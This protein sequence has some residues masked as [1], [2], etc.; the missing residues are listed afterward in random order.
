MIN[1]A[2]SLS[3]HTL[4]IGSY[5]QPMG[6]VPDAKGRGIYTATLDSSTGA[7]V[8]R[9]DAT[10]VDNPS[11]MA[12][13][14]LSELLFAVSESA[15]GPSQL[16]S[17][18]LGEQGLCLVDRLTIA[19]VACCHV[20]SQGGRI[21]CS[22]Y[23]SGSLIVCSH[24]HGLLS[25]EARFS[26]QGEGP[27]RARQQSSHIHQAIV[28]PENNWLYLCDL[29]ADKIWC[30]R[31]K[32]TLEA[33][34][35]FTPLSPGAGPR[36]MV[37]HPTL[38]C[39]YVLCELSA[40]LVVY[41]YHA[42]N[43]LLAKCQAL[44]TLP[45]DFIGQPAAA[46]IIIH[47]SGNALY[48]SNRQHNSVCVYEIEADGCVSFTARFSTGREPRDITLDPLGRFLLVAH[49]DD[50]SIALH[51]VNPNSGFLDGDVGELVSCPT[52]V[53]LVFCQSSA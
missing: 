13:D 29:G 14:A 1:G 12:W 31:L 34:E 21:F 37:F 50:D 16:S 35:S 28:S 9:G 25:F 39:A 23:M 24:N 43:G 49:Q 11:Y 15:E 20:S 44:N 47:P 26:Y 42:S 46:A 8:I 40:E 10:P 2:D 52:P 7:L 45:E 53:N 5:T 22:S 18:R 33:T 3:L 41:E 38:S 4:W 48:V 19:G 6:H 36:H 30:H 27:D 32:A 17:Y 51:R